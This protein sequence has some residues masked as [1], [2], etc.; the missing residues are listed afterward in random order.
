MEETVDFEDVQ[1]EAAEESKLIQ[2]QIQLQKSQKL[3]QV[4]IQPQ[5]A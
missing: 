2:V 5:I 3:I 1:E 4:Q